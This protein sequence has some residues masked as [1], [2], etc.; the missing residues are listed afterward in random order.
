[1]VKGKDE[2]GMMNASREFGCGEDFTGETC[3]RGEGEGN[4]AVWGRYAVGRQM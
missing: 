1:M 2:G 3:P 4:Q